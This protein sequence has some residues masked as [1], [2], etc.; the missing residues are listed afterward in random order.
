MTAG[1]PQGRMVRVG[2]MEEI[3][4]AVNVVCGDRASVLYMDDQIK[5][6][7]N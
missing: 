4:G 2:E 3:D 6:E 1:A 5:M 7:P